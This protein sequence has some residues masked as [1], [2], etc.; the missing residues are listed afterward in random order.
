VL[1]ITA[2]TYSKHIHPRDR[3]LRTVFGDGAAA[4]LIEAC[5]DSTLRAFRFGTDGSGGDTLLVATGGARPP[6]RALKP[7]HRHRWPSNLYMDG[8][9]LISFTVKAVP[10]LVD[11]ILEDAQLTRDKVDFYVL[12]QATYKMIDQL[13]RRLALEE[14]HVPIVLKHCGNTVSSTVPIVIDQLRRDGRL[15]PGAL[16]LLVGFG[17]GWSWAGCLWRE[18]WRGGPQASAAGPGEAAGGK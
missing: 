2:E 16:S 9:A 12:H 1:L 10:K 17:V 5:D 14:E 15:R 11:K 8:P 13:R 3:S 18:T 7:R 6:H 4:T